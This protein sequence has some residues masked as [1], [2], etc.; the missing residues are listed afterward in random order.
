MSQLARAAPWGHARCKCCGDQPLAGFGIEQLDTGRRRRL[1]EDAFAK[2][3][4]EDLE[5]RVLSLDVTAAQ[6][7]GAIAASQCR[8]GRPVEIR[9]VQIAGIAV[10][11]KG[12]LA[13]RN[14]RHFLG[15]GLVLVDPWSD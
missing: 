12:T 9:D 15:I 1:L 3:V 8:A 4:E 5:G 14:T 11:R 13:T 7:A 2:A 6:A 10:A